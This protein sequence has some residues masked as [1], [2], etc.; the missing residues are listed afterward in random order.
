MESV[1]Y[2]PFQSLL[3]SQYGWGILRCG[4]CNHH[5]V[6][7]LVMW[8]LYIKFKKKIRTFKAAAVMVMIYTV[9][10]LDLILLVNM[11]LKLCEMFMLFIDLFLA[12]IIT[13]LI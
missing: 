5:T 7:H 3:Y 8:V 6:I 11:Q 1:L 4:V 13:V 2:L 9:N 10:R 12:A